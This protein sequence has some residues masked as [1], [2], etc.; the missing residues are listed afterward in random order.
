MENTHTFKWPQHL[1]NFVLCTEKKYVIKY[2]GHSN[3]VLI[4][5]A[6]SKQMLIFILFNSFDLNK[7]V[8]IAADK[9]KNWTKE[10]NL[11]GKSLG[12][13]DA[14]VFYVHRH[15]KRPTRTWTSS[16]RNLFGWFSLR[17][18]TH[19]LEMPQLSRLY[20]RKWIF[21]VFHSHSILCGVCCTDNNGEAKETAFVM[22]HTQNSP[23]ELVGSHE[24]HTQVVVYDKRCLFFSKIIF[25]C[26]RLL[27]CIPVSSLAR[28]F[29][30]HKN[31]LT[32]KML[33]SI[34]QISLFTKMLV[35]AAIEDLF[36]FT[37][38]ISVS[39]R[40]R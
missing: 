13:D 38:K 9:R 1:N 34:N 8:A 36:Q 15:R 2:T 29:C 4:I 31:Q 20:A 39:I 37:Y 28:F 33:S 6:T 27:I 17:I 23:I 30:I 3:L 10:Y 21:C 12:C 24:I 22:R 19:S 14:H 25:F 32:T 11:H 5:S 26:F 35:A 7:L 40:Q 16:Y 18:L